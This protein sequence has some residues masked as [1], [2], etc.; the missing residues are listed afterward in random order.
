MA[1]RDETEAAAFSGQQNTKIARVTQE[2]SI[3][4]AF[5]IFLY[6]HVV[7]QHVRAAAVGAS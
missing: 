7:G 1:I 6:N 3:Q 2:R 4:N 5:S